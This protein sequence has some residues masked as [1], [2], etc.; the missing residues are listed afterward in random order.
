VTPRAGIL[1]LLAAALQLGAAAAETFAYWVQ[2]CKGSEVRCQDGDEQLAL[3]A[4]SAWEKAS[5][6]SLKLTPVLTEYQARIRVYWV[7]GREGLYGETRGIVRDAVH[8]ADVY[9]RPT[10]EGLG[11]EIAAVTSRDKLFRDSIVYLTVLHESGHALGLPH[12]RGYDDIMYSFA[13]GGDIV[14]YFAR[15]R[16]KLE[17]RDT[18]A[19]A[20]GLSEEDIRRVKLIYT[21]D[22]APRQ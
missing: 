12:T 5:A 4:L 11:P 7:S 9:V 6:G 13:Y 14:E 10:Q 16:R 22:K 20:S 17:K 2:P 15:Y 1:I 8:G 21:G 18:I 3:W 19:S